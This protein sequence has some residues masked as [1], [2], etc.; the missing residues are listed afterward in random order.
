MINEIHRLAKIFE[1][2]WKFSYLTTK[3]G[4]E[5]DL[6]IDQSQSARI[7]IEIKSTDRVDERE[8]AAFKR[9]AQDVPHAKKLFISQDP[10]PQSYDTVTCLHWQ[11]AL[12]H[13]FGSSI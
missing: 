2:D 4:A 11:E 9:L 5:I 1:K 6:I 8:V 7:V 10:L 12:R 3:D 13:I